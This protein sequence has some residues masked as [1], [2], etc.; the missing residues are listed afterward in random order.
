MGDS[1]SDSAQSFEL[2]HIVFAHAV[3][4]RAALS[5]ALERAVALNASTTPSLLVLEADV[6]A[7]EGD[8][9]PWMSHD[10][11][12]NASA[13]SHL[14]LAAFLEASASR[15]VGVKLDVKEQAALAPALAAVASVQ[16]AAVAAGSRAWPTLRLHAR[17]GSGS[18][19]DKP[20]LFINADVLAADSPA[21]FYTPKSTSDGTAVALSPVDAAR[22]FVQQVGSALP[23]AILSLGWA[24]S[25]AIGGGY[26]GG[27]LGA[28]AAVVDDVARAGVA[29]TYAVRAEYLP[30]AWL[31]LRAT[32]LPPAYRLA[33][34]TVWSHRPPSRAEAEW[35]RANMDAERT[36]YDLPPAAVTASAGEAADADGMTAAGG[37]AKSTRGGAA[38]REGASSWV[39]LATLGAVIGAV[40]AL[41]AANVFKRR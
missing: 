39:L 40:L 24:T 26:S 7:G 37:D 5:S 25:G 27:D 17:D 8:D 20:A 29:V 30:A 13:E 15:G 41:A 2:R 16:E 11:C 34:L 10:P 12:A 38:W 21:A 3:N 9:G 4:S 18:Y 1:A 6:I 33:S 31:A 19:F 28:M 35:L 14:S 22:A 36:M 23:N 32:L